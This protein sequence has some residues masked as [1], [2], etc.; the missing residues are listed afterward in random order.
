M[1]TKSNLSVVS[2]H[3]KSQKALSNHGRVYPLH[4]RPRVSLPKNSAKKS[5]LSTF[6]DGG[7]PPDRGA[8]S[9]LSATTR[10]LETG[11]AELAAEQQRALAEVNLE[12]MRVK[13]YDAL[14]QQAS[15]SSASRL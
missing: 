7:H 11:L 10:K 6:R 3:F 2:K 1:K 15:V 9:E 5:R 13:L 4:S 8:S 12:K 14:A